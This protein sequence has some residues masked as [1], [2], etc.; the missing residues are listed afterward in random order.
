MSG[1][2][3]SFGQVLSAR[4][5]AMW[6]GGALLG[7]L[8]FAA[9]A[10]DKSIPVAYDKL[11]A[12]VQKTIQRAIGDG[13]VSAIERDVDDEG[14]SFSVTFAKGGKGRYLDVGE[15]GT[16]LDIQIGL[17]ETPAPV[18]NAIKT[19][20][21]QNKLAGI[22]RDFEDGE[23]TYNVDFTLKDGAERTFTVAADGKLLSQQVGLNEV[24]DVV[25]KTIAAH[26]GKGALGDIYRTFDE[27]KIYYDVE[28]TVDGKDRDFTVADNG[29]L[30]NIQVAFADLTKEAKAT[31]KKKIGDGNIVR[32]DKLFGPK[33]GVS[34][35]IE[36][37]AKD[38]SALEFRV[39]PK[40]RILANE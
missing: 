22:E 20:L 6:L 25:R 19:L 2:H 32:I 40:G 18:Q 3:G 24:P 21:G 30:E 8:L 5:Q 7:A 38:G 9:Q 23:V 12:V 36:A 16:L 4:W 15:D 39:G 1:L 10:E 37:K 11:P 31:V 17:E 29:K 27:G 13:K 33:Q 14:V 28:Y 26:L 34:F 35:E